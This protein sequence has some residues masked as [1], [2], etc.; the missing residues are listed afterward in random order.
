MSGWRLLQSTTELLLEVV[1]VQ[2]L[3]L[4]PFWFHNT[5]MEAGSE[6]VWFIDCLVFSELLVETSIRV[7]LE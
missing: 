4:C 5:K 1:D 6:L 7:V 2:V 3:S